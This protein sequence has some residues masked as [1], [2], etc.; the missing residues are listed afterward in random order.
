MS[1]RDV[2]YLLC[3]IKV[4][5]FSSDSI[6]KLINLSHET[7]K[8]AHKILRSVFWGLKFIGHI[9]KPTCMADM[10]W[11]PALPTFTR[12]SMNF[13]FGSLSVG[14]ELMWRRYSWPST[15]T[16]FRSQMWYT[17]CLKL[18]ESY[19]KEDIT[20]LYFTCVFSFTTILW[21]TYF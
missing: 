19:Y 6:Y 2:L 3:G 15:G 13:C 12:L 8:K 16:F 20:T 4:P 1:L 17:F 7:L 9:L 10:E 11:E 14:S 5:T 21:A 18:N